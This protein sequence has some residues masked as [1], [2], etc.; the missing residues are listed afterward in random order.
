MQAIERLGPRKHG[1][2]VRV[3]AK[4]L[5]AGQPT[6]FARMAACVHALR[7]A[8]IVEHGR[9]YQSADILARLIVLA[10][11]TRIGAKWPRWEDGQRGRTA[12]GAIKEPEASRCRNCGA[13]LNDHR[14]YFCRH[15]CAILHN[16]RKY[17]EQAQQEELAR[18]EAERLL[19]HLQAMR[20][21][22]AGRSLRGAQALL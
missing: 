14:Q 1:D 18:S 21:T 8:L 2:V 22:A 19:R 11:L 7:V 12:G 9:R 10:A 15:R 5:V 20:G 13:R 16:N 17:R 4:V 6:P 3:I